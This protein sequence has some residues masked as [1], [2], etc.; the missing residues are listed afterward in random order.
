MLLLALFMFCTLGRHPLGKGLGLMALH[1]WRDDHGNDDSYHR[2]HVDLLGLA[3]DDEQQQQ[4]KHAR[5]QCGLPPD[6]LPLTGG[7]R[8]AQGARRPG[9]RVFEEAGGRRHLPGKVGEIGLDVGFNPLT[10]AL[11]RVDQV[12]AQAQRQAAAVNPYFALAGGAPVN[13]RGV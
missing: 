1:Q 5:H 7:V 3:I 12:D 10:V 6:P 11:R 9:H 13:R 4:P 8:Q 2:S